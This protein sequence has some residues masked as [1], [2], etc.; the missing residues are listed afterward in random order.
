MTDHLILRRRTRRIL[1]TT[2]TSALLAGASLCGLPGA[3][4]QDTGTSGGG[5][6]LSQEGQENVNE[7]GACLVGS[8]SADILLIMDESASLKG[9]NAEPTDKDNLRVDAA[10]DLVRQL[11]RHADDLD[12]QIN[13]KL[14]GFGDGYR[15]G[16][17][18]YG[19]WT[20]VKGRPDALDRQ[21]DGAKDRN[22]D[23]YT[24]YGS[25]LNGA[26]KEFAGAP[27]SDGD[28]GGCQ[29]VL[30]FTDGMITDPDAGR[31]TAQLVEEVCTPGGALSSLRN[32]GVRFFTVGLLPEKDRQ[33]PEELLT[34]MAE[35]KDCTGV[36]GNGA[37]FNAGDD[38][39]GL[40]AAFRNFVPT[41]GSVDGTLSMTEPQRFTLDNSVSPVRLSAQ[42][43]ST[44][45]GT[46]TP[47]LTS[48]SGEKL[49]L[50]GNGTAKLGDAEVTME[51]TDAV[52]GMVDAELTLPDGGNWAGEWT[53]GY[54]APTAGDASYNVK[55]QLL[56]GL[57]V[58]VD[59]LT[60]NGG[61]RLKSDGELHATL[62][63]REGNPRHLDG[64]ATMTATFI[65][66]NGDAVPLG[67]QPTGDGG[68]VVFPLD[69]VSTAGTGTLQFATN[70][71]TRGDGG[72]PGTELSPVSASFAASVSPVNMPSVGTTTL[73]VDSGE[74][75]VDIPV[76]GP[77]KVWVEPATLQ[78]G[79]EG[80]SLPDGVGSVDIS[81][82]NAG[83]D[84]ALELG[85]GE[86]GVLPL[87]VR[88]PQ[89]ADGR[90]SLAPVVHL[91]SDDGATEADVVTPLKGDMTSPV[92]KGVFVGVLVAVLLAT[93]VIPLLVLYAMKAYAGRIPGSPGIHALRIP[94]EVRNG[95]LVR[96]DRGGN[97]DISFDELV[98][99]TPR[100]VASGRDV[101]LAGVP[102][103]VR[104]GANPLS[105]PVVVADASPSISDDG[106]RVGDRAR[107]PLAV[108]NH[109][110]VIRTPGQEPG[111]LRGDVV[112]AVDE[113]ITGERLRSLV[114][115]L[116]ANGPERL[117]RL[118]E[119]GTDPSPEDSNG[120][121]L[122]GSGTENRP[123]GQPVTG[124]PGGFPSA[125]PFGASTPAG[126]ASPGDT[127]FGASPFGP[128]FGA[129][130]F[131]PA[132]GNPQGTPP[133]QGPENPGDNGPGWP[134]G[135]GPS[136]WPSGPGPS[137][138]PSG[139]GPSGN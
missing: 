96:R 4:A 17:D 115:E 110:I 117:E 27:D 38:P 77:G 74:T 130:P 55:V 108:H 68:T 42:P 99:D 60:D 93:L 127:A 81:S 44:I 64:T 125:S 133:A 98:T 33:A 10:K 29:A 134:S 56:P 109:W 41:S 78:S 126:P 86:Q 57:S 136:G 118:A 28:G 3:G 36:P 100:T 70:I 119:E 40:L 131:G 76:T 30:F 6:T 46:V 8:R 59:E 12:A 91:V 83:P 72:K 75:T 19:G 102:V 31:S 52:N 48:P 104:L 106:H 137:G 9:F 73:T 139:P 13:V 66:D 18:S 113:R 5:T 62:V 7:L 88:T 24:R 129:S 51:T 128:A 15:S 101:N 71:T 53:F 35:Q 92:N 2:F 89:L 25:A 50:T 34:R 11:S 138:W 79:T 112:I 32:S 122:P 97:F 105:A 20:P 114:S 65:P 94:V 26:L 37:F 85:E 107:L 103:H 120:A 121:G 61:N 16:A 45:D 87:T 80:T 132:G 63:D 82:P 124:M 21:I 116:D 39:A 22:N 1:S 49:E 95:R 67:E 69:Q 135:P 47:V 14:A 84:S 123:A 54:D 111:D 90:M 58:R 23:G 43:T